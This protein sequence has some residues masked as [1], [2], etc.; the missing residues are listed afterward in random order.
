MKHFSNRRYFMSNK[1]KVVHVRC[2]PRLFEQLQAV[3]QAQG[4]TV[5][6][7]ARAACEDY[8]APDQRPRTLPLMGV[9]GGGREDLAVWEAIKA[10]FTKDKKEFQAGVEAITT[11]AA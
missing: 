3:A 1:T 4:L 6:D 10:E 8:T 7:I 11:K 2:S 5:S 9:I